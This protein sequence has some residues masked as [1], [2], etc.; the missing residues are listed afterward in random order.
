[1]RRVVFGAGLCAMVAAPLLSQ[2][3]NQQP[4]LFRADTHLVQVTVVVQD[5]RTNPV[6]DL[7]AVDFRVF[8]DGKE[9]PI[10][11]FSAD[12]RSSATPA[13][14]VVSGAAVV[15]NQV[16]TTGGVTV[17][18][19][20]RLNTA[21]SDQGQAK[22]NIVKF[23]SQVAPTERIGFYVLD[24]SSVSI[25]HDFTSDTR[26]LLR[27]LARVQ[28]Q[29]S[30]ETMVAEE[31]APTI[32]SGGGMSAAMDA[33][34]D[35]ALARMD[36]MIKADAAKNRADA[37]LSALEAV[38]RHLA[39]IPGRK[40]LIWVSASFPLSFN[41][42]FGTRSM[43][44]EVSIATRAI[45]DANI[46]VYPVDARGLMN[47]SAVVARKPAYASLRNEMPASDSMEMLAERTGGMAY[48]NRNDLGRAM[49]RAM[50]DAKFTYTLGYYPE[51]VK[52]DGHF[53]KISIK[54]RRS[55]VSVRHRSGYLALPPPPQT[56]ESRQNALVR[57]LASPLNA[58]A[59]PL[60]VGL[61][62]AGNEEVTVTLR[63]SP[64]AIRLSQ[65]APDLWEGSVDVAIAQA[66]PSGQLAKALD[67][68]VPLRFT[69]AMRDQALRE[70]LNLN[71]RIRPDPAAHTLRIAVRDPAT[72]SVGSVAIPADTI[73]SVLGK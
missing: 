37:T 70:G 6:T 25:V 67:T 43:Y 54:V 64:S 38:A 44:T 72:G 11:L 47:S 61:E 7:A 23:L 50:D 57:A 59:L 56:S 36:E 34:L 27:A 42:G 12:S 40:N 5:G 18:L 30:R 45:A 2:T 21:W 24:S 48:T 28:G 19:F 8:E 10:A 17:I 51:N 22:Q 41:D 14:S 60:T 65:T 58:I 32:A 3:A 29:V 53:R 46:S 35:A 4:S 69:T 16:P 63:L 26:S 66:L 13:T 71:R 68:T 49:A 31:K 9:Q 33:Q 15:S 73:R 55:G 20:D 62:R 1:M 39:G 52:W